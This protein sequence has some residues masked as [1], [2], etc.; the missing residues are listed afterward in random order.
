MSDIYLAPAVRGF[1]KVEAN[2]GDY[3]GEER[4]GR[5]DG[6]LVRGLPPQIGL[7]DGV[8]GIGARSGHAIRN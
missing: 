7:L 1:Q 6:L 3:G 8:L 5:L 4:T 2:A